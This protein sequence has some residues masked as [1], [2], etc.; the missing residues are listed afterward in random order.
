MIKQGGGGHF[1]LKTLSF[2]IEVDLSPLLTVQE[3][4]L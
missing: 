3:H 1:C 2:D 4:L